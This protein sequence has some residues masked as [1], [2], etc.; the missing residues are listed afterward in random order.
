MKEI[1]DYKPVNSE[2]VEKSLCNFNIHTALIS[3]QL[4]ELT[5]CN[6]ESSAT[7]NKHVEL[8]WEEIRTLKV[9][10]SVMNQSWRKGV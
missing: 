2:N 5:K 10:A 9:E 4:V 6:K 1:D 8:L 3:S 7:F